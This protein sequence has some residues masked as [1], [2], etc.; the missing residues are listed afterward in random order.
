MHSFQMFIVVSETRIWKLV[1]RALLINIIHDWAKATD[2]TGDCVR[3]FVLDY[4][5]A[6]DL[7]DHTL[8]LEKLSC[9]DI[10]PYIISL[11]AVFLSDRQQRVK[12]VNDCYSEWE[13]ISAGGTR[14]DVDDRPSLEKCLENTV[15][16]IFC[17]K[18]K[19]MQNVIGLYITG[20]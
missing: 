6:F 4:K 19:T 3:V 10:N 17:Y 1:V 12:L 20:R 16:G 18:H 11:I 13:S 14:G 2:G 5:K 15:D 8:L 9:Y 7:I